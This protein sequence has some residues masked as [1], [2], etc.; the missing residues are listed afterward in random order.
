ML[1]NVDVNVDVDVDVSAAHQ[2]EKHRWIALKR[3]C[4]RTVHTV[5]L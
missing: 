2:C 1:M 4:Y 5:R 3:Y